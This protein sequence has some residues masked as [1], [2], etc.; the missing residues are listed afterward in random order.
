M[1]V[2]D[3]L[4]YRLRSWLRPAAHARDVDD[5]LR[6]HL[7]LEAA[8]RQAGGDAPVDAVYAARR[9][10]G[11]VTAVAE[12]VR[13]AAGLT[14]LDGLRQDLRFA[15]RSARHAPGFSA[16]AILTLALGIGAG[17][18]MFSVV[19]GVLLR[20]LPI[21]RPDR[22]LSIRM[23]SRRETVTGLRD[24]PVTIPQYLRWRDALRSFAVVAAATGPVPIP[25]GRPAHRSR[26]ARDSNTVRVASVS[27]T[28]FRLAGV[29][30]LAGRT[31]LPADDRRGSARTAVLAY[32]YWRRAYGGDRQVVGHSIVLDGRSYTVIGVMPR[33]FVFPMD[34]QLWVALEPDYGGMG[35]DTNERTFI[36]DMFG[37]LRD[38]V[39]PAAAAAELRTTLAAAART[40]EVLREVAVITPRVRDQLVARVA[41][42]LAVLMAVVVAVLAIA[43]L[44]VTN[45]LLARGTARQHEVAIRLALGAGRWRVVRQL[46]LEALLLALGGAACGLAVAAG[47]VRFVVAQ[48]SLD[49]PRRSLIGLDRGVLLAGILTAVAVGLACGLGPALGVSREALGRTLQRHPS[50]H[51][52]DRSRRRLRDTLVLVEVAMAVVLLAGAGLL[53]RSVRGL[54][55]LRPGLT[56]DGVLVG[57]IDTG[58]PDT[59]TVA[60]LLAARAVGDRL[61]ALPGVAA[62]SVTSSYPFGRAMQIADIDLSGIVLDTAVHPYA[63]VSGID[64]TYFRALGTHILRGRAF[65]PA[66]LQRRDVVIIND[67]LAHRYLGAVDPIGRRI[68]I[69]GFGTRSLEI[70]GVVESVRQEGLGVPPQPGAYVPLVAQGAFNLSVVVRAA[71]GDPLRLVPAVQRAVHEA[72][73]GASLD[74]VA[75]LG[76]LVGRVA[77]RPHV[78]LVLLGGF[79]LLATLLTAV[80]LYGV[81]GYAVAERT[82]EIAIRIALGA[83]PWRVRRQVV[84]HGLLVT[85]AGAAMGAGAA[86][87]ATRVLRSLLYG[88]TPGDPAVL[89]A[90]VGVVIAAAAAACWLPARRAAAV[91]PMTAIRT[92]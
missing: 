10:L 85:A 2:L 47:I 92:E 72:V 53:L 75:P 65:T 43:A 4:R 71:Q 44:N 5:E 91:D 24:L 56:A 61:R 3:A 58:V 69:A 79:A 80:G 35:L 81:V 8:Q 48:P 60:R 51:S 40:H 38:A 77:A 90:V 20:P 13:R 82:R 26:T 64:G 89:A 11:N 86:L 16:I 45:M 52:P 49:L 33:G 6:F 12:D 34:T 14:R 9:R 22:V 66:D 36:V 78:Y 67:A 42:P 41:T 1:S 18:A 39:P 37:R 83:A 27:G 70:V 73:P 7:A 88:V 57:D 54:M 87:I 68:T 31:I 63:M 55:Q 46:L 19:D 84:G 62:A 74:D 23:I 25:L 30:P 29:A 28:F 21:V 76:A 50:R 59:D 15:L 17:T 32:G